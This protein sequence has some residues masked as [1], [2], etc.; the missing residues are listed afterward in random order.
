MEKPQAKFYKGFLLQKCW[1]GYPEMR[2]MIYSGYKW[3]ATA[4]TLEQAK[5]K[6]DY[7]ILNFAL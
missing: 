7:F 5:R 1:C 6:C 2:W 3:L 4:K